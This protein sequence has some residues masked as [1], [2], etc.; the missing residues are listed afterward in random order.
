MEWRLFSPSAKPLACEIQQVPDGFI[1]R[2]TRDGAL[3]FTAHA[4]EPGPLRER[5]TAW[6]ETLESSGYTT[7][8]AERGLPG[9]RPSEVRSALR[10]LV[11]CASVLE[12][13]DAKPAR[14]LRDHATAGLVALALR[15]SATLKG[16]VAGA[17]DALS[18]ISVVTAGAT[19]LIS[20]C[21]ALI[22]RI[23]AAPEYAATP[24]YPAT[25]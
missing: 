2:V 11:E 6:R 14:E 15:D 9:G 23:E 25:D 19:D 17:R 16:A 8:P 13:H 7:A 12:I 1:L 24:G 5:A 3:L 10:G 18:R 20:S 22:G 4:P 21:H